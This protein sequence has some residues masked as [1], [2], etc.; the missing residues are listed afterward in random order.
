MNPFF[1][2]PRVPNVFGVWT[3]FAFHLEFGVHDI[4]FAAAI[5]RLRIVTPFRVEVVVGTL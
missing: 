3:P 4:C 1:M 2:E 5:E